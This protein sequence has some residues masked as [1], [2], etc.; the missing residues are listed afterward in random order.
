MSQGNQ[1][2]NAQKLRACEVVAALVSQ[3]LGATRPLH[4]LDEDLIRDV[5]TIAQQNKLLKPVLKQLE[6]LGIGVPDDLEAD[7]SAYIRKTMRNNAAAI[8]TVREASQKLSEVGVVHAAFKGPVR[9]IALAQDVFE[10]PVADVDI[11]VKSADFRRATES[12]TQLGYA[13]PSTCD[14]PWW[15]HFLGEHALFPADRRRCQIDLHHRVQQP[16]CPRPVAEAIMM[17]DLR[18]VDVGG[19]KINTFGARATFL[20]TVMSIVKGLMNREPTGAHVL[21]L[22]RQMQTA[23][24]SKLADFESIVAAQR[25][26][27]SYAV[28]KRSVLIMTGI[29]AG[30]AP[31]WYV[32]DDTLLSMLLAP[33]DPSIRWP[34]RRYLLWHLVDGESTAARAANF[35]RE[36][37]WWAAAEATRRTHDVS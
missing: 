13:I 20:H 27:Q 16:C 22:A 36:F 10:R 4:D 26:K 25:L 34:E 11:L 18:P 17:E 14:S 29:S 15:R 6:L 1:C 3:T 19:Q 12:L 28:A 35:G 30:E 37:V 31:Q 7:V 9:Q 32:S 8:A 21:D 5:V 2:S 23:S 24:A 33:D